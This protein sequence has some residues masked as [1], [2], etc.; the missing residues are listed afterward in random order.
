MMMPSWMWTYPKVFPCPLAFIP[1]RGGGRP[2]NLCK[3]EKDKVILC[4]RYRGVHVGSSNRKCSD[5]MQWIRGNQDL[6]NSRRMTLDLSCF[7]F[8]FPSLIT[9]LFPC[10][11][12]V[13]PSVL[14]VHVIN[15]GWSFKKWND[16]LQ[17]SGEEK[18]FR[19]QVNENE[20]KQTN[21][22]LF[23]WYI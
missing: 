13:I 17:K 14:C 15:M 16:R 9:S 19:W 1:L 18:G 2:R 4:L 10:I 7:I 21:C 8:T 6:C 22:L 5:S 11:S 12:L 3:W 23:V 20:E